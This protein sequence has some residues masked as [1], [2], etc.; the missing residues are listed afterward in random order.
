MLFAKAAIFILM[1]WL[2]ANKLLLQND[3]NEQ[4]ELFRQN[5]NGEKFYLF[6]IAF[7]LMPVNWLLETVKWRILLQ[8]GKTSFVNLLKG[9]IAGVT[10]GFVTPAR[11]G[12]FIGRV[13]YLDDAH[14]AKVFYLSSI[15]GIAQTA[16]TLVV[17]SL[18]LTA[19]NLDG[20]LQGL[21]VGLACCCVL[22]YFRFDVLNKLL[23]S[24][25]FLVNNGL[26]ISNEEL[27]QPRVQIQVLTIAAVRYGVYLLQYMFVFMFFG[28]SMDALL[29]LLHNALLLL[30]QSFSPLMPWMDISFR[31]GSAL[32]IYSDVTDNNIAVVTAAVCIWVINLVLPAVVG[33]VFIVR[34]K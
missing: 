30:V 20:F 21:A 10:F 32:W 5:M 18:C 19:M 3:F 13:I 27:P 1:A 9:I 8:D 11:S 34:R 6:I 22:F 33:Y 14:K 15:G 29:L 17:G 31:G 2:I 12:E 26:T 28:V 25:P 4:R 23:S 24:V 16:V 7:L